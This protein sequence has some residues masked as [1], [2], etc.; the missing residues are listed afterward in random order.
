MR[1]ISKSNK[2]KLNKRFSFQTW[3][4]Q[5][6][7]IAKS[8]SKLTNLDNMKTWKVYYQKKLTPKRSIEQAK[9]DQF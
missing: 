4:K 1:H 5:V 3:M 9:F 7:A 8:D 2:R 6:K